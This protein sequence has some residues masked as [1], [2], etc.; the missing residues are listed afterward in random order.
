M[1]YKQGPTPDT[2]YQI[3]GD[4]KQSFSINSKPMTAGYF[5]NIEMEKWKAAG[6]EIE[7]FETAEEVTVREAKE[8]RESYVNQAN[9]ALKMIEDNEY[10]LVSVRK[11]MI[12]DRAI[13]ENI[14]D[15]W[16]DQYVYLK[17]QIELIDEGKMP[18]ALIELEPEPVLNGG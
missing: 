3:S 4:T 8:L 13:W 5:M 10:H 18:G 15:I 7:P 17:D 6:N 14:I 2:F 9:A 1:K 16:D 11:K 12:A